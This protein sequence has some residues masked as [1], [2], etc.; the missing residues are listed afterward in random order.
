MADKER[1]S[2][3]MYFTYVLYPQEDIEHKLLL[4][5]I[6]T[7]YPYAYIKHPHEYESDPKEHIHIIFKLGQQSTVNGVNKF[8]GSDYVKLVENLQGAMQYLVHDTP[9]CIRE[10]LQGNTEKRQFPV[11]NIV[12]NSPK[13]LSLISQKSNFVHLE[14]VMND[15]DNGLSIWESIKHKPEYER[16]YLLEFM[17]THSAFIQLANQHINII[18]KR[19]LFGVDTLE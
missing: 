4:D 14:E 11:C 5:F 3:S 12:T 18:D 8:F 7:H 1:A 16:A 2:R 13:W 17:T 19:R 9:A 15:I 6:T 10:V